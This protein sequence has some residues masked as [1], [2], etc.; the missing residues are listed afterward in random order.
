MPSRSSV[1]DLSR[2]L[3]RCGADALLDASLSQLTE[4]LKTEDAA[5][6]EVLRDLLATGLA[7]TLRD[8]LEDDRLDRWVA[9]TCTQREEEALCQRLM[10]WLG[11]GNHGDDDPARLVQLAAFPVLSTDTGAAELQGWAIEHGV[12]DLLD[13]RA[14]DRLPGRS[15]LSPELNIAVCCQGSATP[16]SASLLASQTIA[17]EARAF[18]QEQAAQRG[19]AAARASLWRRPLTHAA[20]RQLASRLHALLPEQSALAALAAVRFIPARPVRVDARTG[21]GEGMLL[22]HEASPFSVKLHLSGYEQRALANECARCSECCVHVQALAARLLDALHAPDDRLHAGLRA[23]CERPSWQR[24]VAALQRDEDADHAASSEGSSQPGQL[25][26]RLRLDE[27]AISVGVLLQKPLR[28]GGL[29]AG[30]LITPL[31][32]ARMRACS[33]LDRPLLDALALTT[34][35]FAAQYTR[36]DLAT[37]R[38]L[39][40]HPRVSL[41]DGD[42]TLRLAEQSLHVELIEQPEGLLPRVSLAGS[43]VVAAEHSLQ[44]GYLFRHDA[45]LQ[46]LWFAPLTPPLRRLLTA[47]EHFHGLL[48]PESF[49]ALSSWLAE[50]RQ[51]ARVT[52]PPALQGEEL[53]TL[54]RLLLRI[55]PG[56]DEGI[57]VALS[58]RPLP[59]GALW[60][61]GQGPLL[62]HGLV[63]GRQVCTR[64][65]LD[66]ERLAGM[67]M[68][69]AL[70]AHE[71]PRLQPFIYRVETQQ[72]ALHMLARA[73]ELTSTLDLEWS[74]AAGRL[75]L[76]PALRAETLSIRVWKRSGHWLT[77]EGSARDPAGQVAL[78][79]LLEAARRGERFVRVAEGSYAQITQ[80]LFERL[81]RAQ[82]C[83]G[84]LKPGAAL[85]LP[86]AAVAYWQAALGEHTEAA[87][88]DT[89]AWL[90]LAAAHDPSELPQLS[91]RWQATLR[92]Y[93]ATGARWL[94]QMSSWAP[95][96]C[97]A[98]EMGLGKTVQ[99]I[100]LLDARAQLGPALV[101]A[102]TSVVANWA[103]ELARFA[104]EL[105][106][107]SYQGTDR[108][109]MLEALRPGHV[110]LCS[111]ELLLRDKVLFEPLQFA[112]QIL[113]EAH[114][115]KN[116][117]TARARA[118]FG[119]HAAFRVALSGTPIENRL[120]DL[121]SLLHG[122]APGL[123]G[124]WAHFR[125]LFAVPIERYGDSARAEAL[126]TLIAPFVL[127]R[128][129]DD[130]ASELP[131]RTEVVH[132]FA[133]SEPERALYQAAER[134]IRSALDKRSLHETRSV[135]ILAELTRLRLL[136]CHPRLV[137][138]EATVEST[139]LTV[140]L[141]LLD[142]ILPRGHRA[143][144]FS[145]F[146]R[147]LAL[148]REALDAR[149]L[150]YLY[151]DGSTPAGQRS[152]LVAR[153]Q[154]GEAPLF[155]ISL[156]AGGVGL[157]LTAADYVIHLD[158]WWNPAAE[159]QASDRAHRLGQLRPVTVIKLVAEDTIEEKVVALHEHKRELA[160]SII[161]GTDTPA[162]LDLEVLRSLLP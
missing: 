2:Q 29:S 67:Q 123:L 159:D 28:S 31:R 153:F 8:A 32:A 97:L 48:P 107:V 129:K 33:E 138:Q 25:A 6:A 151:L 126:R 147:H 131:A 71:H 35:S 88:P 125:A 21:S 18:L 30:K 128:T 19:A 89:R 113:D 132:R 56:L 72:A 139:K 86:A 137:L 146:T 104:P 102:P 43:S 103:A 16:R 92:D 70:G 41:G 14:R 140:L 34:R 87:T 109:R 136:A 61:P 84:E 155:L 108:E 135:Q 55:T 134:E 65:D 49:S 3:L 62:V 143:L 115:I 17:E 150:D 1:F 81:E 79:R 5:A 162:Q 142:D 133:L 122:I 26:F 45:R 78:E 130:V 90:A 52:V 95:G 64:R 161:H 105:A 69:E 13:A 149:G 59:L 50:V 98:D 118:A 53:P 80:E 27:R 73:A 68:L 99:A 10:R 154:A 23:L 20:T 148:V 127:R 111:Y 37:L 11:T 121:W 144:L 4:R 51:V 58:S 120:G 7:E 47:L 157:N 75:T 145:Q 141:R 101:V 40:E 156:K 63:D 22:D 124:D 57:E 91:K 119:L 85:A 77:L 158:P 42:Q 12:A 36:V 106:V 152:P 66:W 39:V 24:F 82:L 15:E 160:E 117:R 44:S 110:V 114:L 74:E 116:A 54:R 100:S 60:P 46:T 94:L 83:L 112:T 93:Q 76:L 38:A 96:A 9:E